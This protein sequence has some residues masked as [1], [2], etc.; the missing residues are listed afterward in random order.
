MKN[1]FLIILSCTLTVVACNAIEYFFGTGIAMFVCASAL[2]I[3]IE[4]LLINDTSNESKH[5]QR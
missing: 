4:I 1:V 5:N 2:L 3:C